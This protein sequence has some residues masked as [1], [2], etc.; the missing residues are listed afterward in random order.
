L[1]R[2]SCILSVLF[3]GGA[4]CALV[5][6]ATTLALRPPRG[7]D[8]S[9]EWQIDL[10]LSDFPQEAVPIQPPLSGTADTSGTSGGQGGGHRRG[11]GGMGGMGG[12]MGGGPGGGLAQGGARPGSPEHHFAMPPHLSIAQS[13]MSVIVDITQPDGKHLINS[14]TPGEK[15]VV[16]TT[17]GAADRTLGWE[18]D[19]FLIRT[20]VGEKGSRSEVRY[21][22]DPDGTLSVTSTISRSGIY[23]FQYTLEYDRVAP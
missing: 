4:V 14:Y 10:P 3:V 6:C 13:A 23:D 19:D 5:G 9:G 2:L 7:I 12:G 17:R 1:S 11:P 18:G 22:L 16:A 21:S 8:L 15:T 20:Q